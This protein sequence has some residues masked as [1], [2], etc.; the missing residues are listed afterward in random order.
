M[1]YIQVPV[2]DYNGIIIFL[3][4]KNISISLAAQL[5]TME[6]DMIGE[7]YIPSFSPSC[8]P[9]LFPL[10]PFPSP[11]FPC[12]QN[13]SW[14]V[15]RLIVAA[16]DSVPSVKA[17]VYQVSNLIFI[18][19]CILF[20]LYI[21]LSFIFIFI[22]TFETNLPLDV[23]ARPQQHCSRVHIRSCS[24]YV[25]FLI[26][27]SFFYHLFPLLDHFSCSFLLIIY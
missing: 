7:G 24:W 11:P 3:I 22:F 10:F 12:S 1:C 17:Q 9:F 15:K 19:Y 4:E 25:F 26:F 20:N 16:T 2:L 21:Y 5:Q 18:F 6:E 8:S 23:Q 14:S 27:W 13:Y